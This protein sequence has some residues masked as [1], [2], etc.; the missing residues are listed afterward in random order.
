MSRVQSYQFKVTTI[1][2]PGYDKITIGLLQGYDKGYEKKAYGCGEGLG[3][4]SRRY[5]RGCFE[6][7]FAADHDL[8]LGFKVLVGFR[9][10]QRLQY[11]VIRG[12]TLQY[13]RNFKLY[14][15]IQGYCS[16]WVSSTG[17]GFWRGRFCTEVLGK[18]FGFSSQARGVLMKFA[19]HPEVWV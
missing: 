1:L 12:Y 14:S 15:L 4:S 5:T 11:P 7:G 18:A 13:K 6:L 16:L 8:G 9:A 17:L 19:R 2:L 3:R 10:S